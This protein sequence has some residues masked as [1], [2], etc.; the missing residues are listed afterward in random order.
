VGQ[1]PTQAIL[2]KSNDSELKLTT[3]L[4]H[5]MYFKHSCMLVYLHKYLRSKKISN[6][7]PQWSSHSDAAPH[8]ARCYG[9]LPPCPPT[10]HRL[11][12][13]PAITGTTCAARS[14]LSPIARLIRASLLSLACRA[15]H[16]RLAPRF[17]RAPRCPLPPV[18]HAAHPAEPRPVLLV[19]VVVVLVRRCSPSD[20]TSTT[21][22]DRPRHSSPLC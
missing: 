22:I 2:I 17:G 13:S 6:A 8:S 12:L 5:Q 1:L 18:A 11:L 4:C 20:P 9:L 19:L 15:P 21:E 16:P 7:W 10:L 14:S 3:H